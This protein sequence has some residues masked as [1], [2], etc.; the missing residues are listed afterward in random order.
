ML[1]TK[2]IFFKFALKTKTIFYFVR[3]PQIL[4]WTF[5]FHDFCFHSCK[6]DSGGLKNSRMFKIRP[7]T[8]RSPAAAASGGI[9]QIRKFLS[10][11]G[12][13]PASFGVRI[14]YICV[15]TRQRQTKDSSRAGYYFPY[16]LH[17]EFGGFTARK[18]V[19]YMLI[20]S[21]T[22][23]KLRILSV[24]HMVGV[25]PAGDQDVPGKRHT[26]KKENQIFLI[27]KEIHNGAVAKSYMTNGLLIYGEKIF[28]HFLIF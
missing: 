27:Y 20:Y 8:V 18:L 16:F 1:C 6:G 28:A 13:K 10:V 24:R 22:C 4:C 17:K 26:D 23:Q 19:H 25:A 14:Y 2:Y 15:L 9:L 21:A 5:S 7:S 11:E 3:L 12:S